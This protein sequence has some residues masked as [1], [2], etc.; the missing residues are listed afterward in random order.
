MG[1]GPTGHSGRASFA[2]SRAGSRT[3]RRADRDA[4]PGWS[5]SVAPVRAARRRRPAKLWRS[6]H[7]VRRHRTNRPCTPRLRPTP[8]LP[9]NA[10]PG[11]CPCSPTPS[12]TA[13]S[14]S[15]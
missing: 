7:D 8:T 15:C 13:A 6:P 14:W 9:K 3:A 11:P 4:I 1:C 10:K 12:A 2:I 5:D